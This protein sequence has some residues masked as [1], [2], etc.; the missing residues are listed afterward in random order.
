MRIVVM[1][2]GA[3]GCLY[4]GLLKLSGNEVTL[5]GRK[6]HIESVNERGLILKGVFGDHVIHVEATE[7]ASDIKSCDIVLITTKS[8]DTVAAAQEIAHLVEGGASVV[9][10]QNGLGTE[11]LVSDTLES[12]R[13]LRATT[14]VGALMTDDGEVTATGKGLTEV[15]SH[16]PSN[17][18]LVQQVVDILSRAGFD[19]IPSDNIEGVV[20]TKTIVN[21][22]LN[23]IAALTGMKNGEIHGDMRLRELVVRLVEEAARVAEALDVR[24]S[25]D[26]PIRYTLGT[27]KATSDNTNSMLQDICSCKRTE[28]DAITGEVIR[29]AKELDVSTPYSE[30]VYA[31]VKALEAKRID[32]GTP[33][34]KARPMDADEIYERILI[35]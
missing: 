9:C 6:R 16:I 5:V 28:I 34:E 20:W 35:P 12:D 11:L 17:M 18:N 30:S 29:L 22:G 10:L 2:S 27:A 23:P 7:N 25:T 26:D 1:G 19:V 32:I 3:I 33:D 31:L 13:V 8:Y 4:G 21:C 15:G 14:C 24:L